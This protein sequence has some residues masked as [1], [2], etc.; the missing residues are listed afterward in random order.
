MWPDLQILLRLLEYQVNMAIRSS[1]WKRRRTFIYSPKSVPC[2]SI[3]FKNSM[4]T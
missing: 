2:K 1:N 4:V 3:L